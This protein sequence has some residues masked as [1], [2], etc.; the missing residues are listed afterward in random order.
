MRRPS[1]TSDGFRHAIVGTVVGV[2]AIAA[3]LIRRFV[4]DGGDG[5]IVEATEVPVFAVVLLGCYGP[6]YLALT[7]LAFRRAHGGALR[8][9]LLRTRPGSR[10]ARSILIGGPKSWALTVAAVGLITVALVVLNPEVQRSPLLVAG[11]IVAI[12]GT[13]ILLVAVFASEYAR[14]W[15]AGGAFRFPSDDDDD[16]TFGD[17]LYLAVQLSTTF[18]SS[19]VQV[20]SRG[21]RSVVTVHSLVAFA[22]NT[23]IVAVF[24]SV[25]IVITTG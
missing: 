18:G 3:V 13:W 10:V 20:L 14:L 15:A 19:D 7:A 6:L 17:F 1:L 12:I 16:R 9:R 22:Y 21:A 8:R 2:A 23:V 24:V 25:L 4:G 11:C 5:D